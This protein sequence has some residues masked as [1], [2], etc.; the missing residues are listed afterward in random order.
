MLTPDRRACRTDIL[1]ISSEQE[2]RVFN[3]DFSHFL[4][5]LARHLKP[6]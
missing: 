6:I 2:Q 5:Q 4:D 3:P 1:S